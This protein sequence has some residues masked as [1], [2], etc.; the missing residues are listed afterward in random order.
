MQ[1]T[2]SFRIV[3][4]APA[5]FEMQ[6]NPCLALAQL[7]IGKYGH[8]GCS[9]VQQLLFSGVGYDILVLIDLIGYDSLE[10]N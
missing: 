5:H 10:L 4:S 7:S 2:V 9:I 1:I 3:F 8:L 6:I